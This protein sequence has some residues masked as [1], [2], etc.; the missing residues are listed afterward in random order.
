MKNARTMSLVMLGLIVGLAGCTNRPTLFPNSDP[1]LRKTSTQFAADSAKRFPYKSDAPRAGKAAANAEVDYGYNCLN[2]VNCSKEDWKNVELWVN[3]KYVVF[4][5]NMV[6]GKQVSI[7]FTMI[8][9]DAGNYL[10]A[11]NLKTRITRLEAYMDGKMYEIP[12]QL[13]D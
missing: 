9:D 12:V 3:Q 10:P 8:F 1:D 4:V 13:A 11:A 5:P 2:V 6:H 7:P